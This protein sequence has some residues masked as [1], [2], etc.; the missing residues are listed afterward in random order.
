MVILANQATFVSKPWL[1]FFT[2]RDTRIK[3]IP[4]SVVGEPVTTVIWSVKYP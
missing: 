3:V 2:I 1:S 4:P